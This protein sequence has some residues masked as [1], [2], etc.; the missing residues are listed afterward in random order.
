[1]KKLLATVILFLNC[2]F[3]FG[4]NFNFPTEN[5]F[6][7]IPKYGEKIEEFIPSNWELIKRG[8]GDLNADKNQDAVLVIKGT[9]TKFIN[10][11][12]GLGEEKFDTNPRILIILFKE[13]TGY[14]LAKQSNTFIIVPDSPTMSEPFQSLEIKNRVFQLDFEVWYSAGSWAASQISYKFRFQNGDFVLIGVDKTESMRNSGEMETRSY[15]FLTNKVKISTGNFSSDAPLKVRWRNFKLR[16]LKT[17]DTFKKPLSW[18]IEPDY[19][20]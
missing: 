4:Q 2:I 9:S 16:K 13:K 5:D 14:R 10:K 15:N 3:V 18:E 6:P 7:T 20:V 8:F 12:E 17:F 1:M 11:N 19:Y